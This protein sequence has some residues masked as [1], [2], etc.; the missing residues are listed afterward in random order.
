MVRRSAN[1]RQSLQHALNKNDPILYT[2]S[3]LWG[4]TNPLGTQ[5]QGTSLQQSLPVTNTHINHDLY[6]QLVFKGT[7]LVLHLETSKK[8]ISKPLAFSLKPPEG[9]GGWGVAGCCQACSERQAPVDFTCA[10]EDIASTGDYSVPRRRPA[11]PSQKGLTPAPTVSE[12]P[13]SLQGAL[14]LCE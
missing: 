14:W 2:K 5:R 7:K 12:C 3:I 13:Q 1:C 8:L 4:S 11:P 9:L 10:R 6:I